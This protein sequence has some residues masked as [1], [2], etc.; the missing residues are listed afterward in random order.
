MERKVKPKISCILCGKAYTCMASLTKQEH[1]HKQ[2]EINQ[3]VK[4]VKPELLQCE[5]CKYESNI[6]SSIDM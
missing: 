2:Q 5:F 4:I 3:K 6:K 1:M